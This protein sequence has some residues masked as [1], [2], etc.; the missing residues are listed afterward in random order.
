M[1][2][3]LLLEACQALTNQW[4]KE[5]DLYLCLVK[6]KLCS[7]C[8]YPNS[9]LLRGYCVY[10]LQQIEGMYRLDGIEIVW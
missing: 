9:R 3:C 4:I 5:L 2:D 6:S 7:I 1:V 10:A 8:W